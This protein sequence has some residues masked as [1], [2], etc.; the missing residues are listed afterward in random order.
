MSFGLGFWAAAGAGAVSSAAYE[1]IQTIGISANGITTIDFQSIPQTYKH[2]QIRFTYQVNTAS[3]NQYQLAILPNSDGSTTDNAFHWLYGN[4]SSVISLSS[5]NQTMGGQGLISYPAPNPA[6]ININPSSLQSQFLGGIVDFVDYASTS[7]NKTIR[8]FS[9]FAMSAANNISLASSVWTD[10]S[11]IN[12]I[13]MY[14][15]NG[16]Q[17]TIGTRFSL[18]GIKG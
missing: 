16:P 18:Y 10:T 3:N 14:C 4:G 11:A 17:F 15:S 6:G 5:T 2:L 7:K 12:R 8:A 1:L 13:F 9:G